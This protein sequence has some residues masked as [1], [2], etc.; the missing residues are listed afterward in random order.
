VEREPAPVEDVPEPEAIV[1]QAPSVQEEPETQKSAVGE[2]EDIFS[3]WEEFTEKLSKVGRT[4]GVFM[5]EGTPTSFEKD[6]LTVTFAPEQKYHIQTLNKIIK[7]IQKVASEVFGTK[8]TLNLLEQNGHKP[9]QRKEDEVLSH[10]TSQH[11]LDIFD[12][13]II[14]E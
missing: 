14:D 8:M 12:G 5:G 11:L 10:P 9:K 3:K 6:C 4:T 7:D 2:L 13:E 1:A